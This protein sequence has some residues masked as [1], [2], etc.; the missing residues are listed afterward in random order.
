MTDTAPP[1][2]DPTG[3]TGPTGP[4]GRNEPAGPPPDTLN[5]I[6]VLRRREIEARIVAPLLARFAEEFGAERVHAVA[7]DV[8]VD[9][10]RTQGRALAEALGGNDIDAF[11]SSLGAWTKDD[12]LR[13]EVV[14]HSAD[15]YAFNV[16]R[17]R[18]AEL[19][20]ALGIAE[21]GAL[22]SCDRD[23]T[24]VEGFNDRMRFERTQTIMGGATHC[25]FRYTLEPPA[26]T[27]VAAPGT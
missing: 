14:E 26:E 24:M 8:I 25:D 7:R 2:S 12:A 5:E 16:T 21:L 22:L 15:T 27:A 4:A 23:G 1:P 6:G 10:A 18:Y 17:C 20:R 11:A 3:R 9:V 13:V 19:Y